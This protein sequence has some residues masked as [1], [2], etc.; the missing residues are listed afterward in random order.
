MGSRVV[1]VCL[2]CLGPIH[3]CEAL[4]ILW[5]HLFFIIFIYL[6]SSLT[7]NLGVC[8]YVHKYTYGGNKSGEKT[9]S[10]KLMIL[11]MIVY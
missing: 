8:V 10:Q 5:G 7:K 2:S 9:F 11:F 4:N 1:Y 6:D 3:V